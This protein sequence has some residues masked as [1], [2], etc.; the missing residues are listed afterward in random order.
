MK[1]KIGCIT[2][3]QSPRTDVVPELEPIL[4]PNIEII[5][6]GALDGLTKEEI[7]QFQPEEGDYILVSKLRDGTPVKFAERCI[8]PRLQGCIDKLEAEGAQTIAFLC[9]GDFPDVFRSKLPVL[10]PGTVL[11]HCIQP[12][13]ITGKLGVLTPDSAQKKQTEGKWKNHVREVAVASGSP[14]GDPG[15]IAR[16]AGELKDRELDLIIMDCIGYNLDMR[17]TVREITGKP[18]MLGRTMLARLIAEILG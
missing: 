10:Y 4:G 13:L 7:D 18:V 12:L 16:A 3:G 11:K 1:C 8:L 6:A 14:Y 5:Q 2:I 15:E 17:K 9:T